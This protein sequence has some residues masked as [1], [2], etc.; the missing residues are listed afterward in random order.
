MRVTEKGQVTIPKPV[1]DRLGIV[2]GSEVDFV[3]RDGRTVLVK[4]E[5][6]RED[7]DHRLQELREHLARIRGTGKVGLTSAELID[8]TR[9]P[10]NDV[11]DH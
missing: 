3:F 10:Y 9:G 6:G 11:D 2:P 1:R 8:M 5:P 4:I 7:S